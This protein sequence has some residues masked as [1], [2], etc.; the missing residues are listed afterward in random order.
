VAET[1]D[2][3]AARV[4]HASPHLGATRLV[5]V[6]GPAGAGKSTYA[7]ALART[8]DD[9]PLVHLDDLY[10]GWLGLRPDLYT[11]LVDGLLL[12]LTSGVAGGYHRYDWSAERFAEWHEI[13]PAEVMIL[14]GVGS[15][16]R[17]VDRFAALRVWVD[18]PPE[19]RLTRGLERDG[20]E[21]HDKWVQ[22]MADESAHFATDGTRD[23]ADVV[24][25]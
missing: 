4:R 15:A 25:G 13:A 12:P 3:V 18:A 9:A 19:L 16:A 17:P 7:D 22:W 8:L 6:D 10:E 24:V 1:V 20:A 2:V 14:E 11:R 23:R 5:V 21:M